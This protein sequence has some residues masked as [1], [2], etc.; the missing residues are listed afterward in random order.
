MTRIYCNDVAPRDGF[1][2]EKTFIPTADKVALIDALSM[3]GLA[4]IEVDLLRFAQGDSCAR[5]RR[6]RHGADPPG[7]GVI[8]TVLVPNVRGAERALDGKADEFNLVMSASETHN[9]A[10][11]RMT[12]EQSLAA[13]GDVLALARGAGVPVNASLSCCFG[14]PMEGDVADRRGAAPGRGAAGAGRA[15]HH[16]VRHH[17]HGVSDAGR[18]AH[19]PLHRALSGRPSSRCTSTTRAA[20]RWPTCSPASPPARGASMPRSAASAVARMRRAPPAMPAS[21]TWCRCW[22]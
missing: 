17:R 16:A 3:T 18:A 2:N 5:R 19:A 13:L 10:N 14:C 4:K 1:Q 12:R 11:L 7:P 8:Y 22:R 6:G 21:R 20:W 9:L 15:R